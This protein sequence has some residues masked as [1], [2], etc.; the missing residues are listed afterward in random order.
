M[1]SLNNK[2]MVS[3][4]GRVWAVYMTPWHCLSDISDLYLCRAEKE[5]EST[6]LYLLQGSSFTDFM[7]LHPLSF[8]SKWLI[9]F[10]KTPNLYFSPDSRVCTIMSHH[11]VPPAKFLV[12]SRLTHFDRQS[13]WLWF[14]KENGLIVSFIIDINNS[15]LVCYLKLLAFTSTPFVV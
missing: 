10:H 7:Q 9:R 4:E 6:C 5:E 11:V 8:L 3:D 12:V 1:L 13:S 2:A 14:G 15:L